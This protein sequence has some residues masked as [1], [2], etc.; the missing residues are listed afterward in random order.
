MLELFNE[1][2][3]SNLPLH[4][5]NFGV[6]TLLL[7][8]VEAVKIQQYRCI[9]LLSIRF[10]VFTKVLA[11][12]INLIANKVIRPSQTTFILGRHIME[13]VVILH[14]TIHYMHNKKISEIILKLYFLKAYEMVKWP[15]L[16]EVLRMKGFSL[17][18]CTWINEVA[19]KGFVGVK[20]NNN[21][22]HFFQP[23]KEVRQGDPCL[24]LF[25]MWW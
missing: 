22:G 5:L 6:T 4:R 25:L 14:E 16:P 18:W 21:G 9:C 3:A 8:K 11:N 12:R 10:K 13:G 2:H 7:K 17:K 15:F 23:T 1:Y 24:L 20:V 19:S